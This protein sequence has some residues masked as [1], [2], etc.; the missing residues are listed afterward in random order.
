MNAD[1]IRDLSD[2]EREQHRDDIKTELMELQSQAAAGTPPENPGRIR[3]IKRTLARMK[4][5]ERE[6]EEHQA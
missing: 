1:D 5:I 6:E 4:T 3:A 2:D